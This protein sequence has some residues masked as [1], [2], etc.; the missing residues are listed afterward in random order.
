MKYAVHQYEEQDSDPDLLDR[1]RDEQNSRR[2]IFKEALESKFISTSVS[3]M[4][5]IRIRRDLV[6]QEILGAYPQDTVISRELYDTDSLFGECLIWMNSLFEFPNWEGRT[7]SEFLLKHG[8]L[9]EPVCLNVLQHSTRQPNKDGLC[10]EN[11][12]LQDLLDAQTIG[13]KGWLLPSGLEVWFHKTGAS[14]C[15]H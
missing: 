11:V 14:S 5:D 2:N 8:I 7:V 15:N 6:A 1:I 10:A 12:S 4:E 3:P 13:E 9:G